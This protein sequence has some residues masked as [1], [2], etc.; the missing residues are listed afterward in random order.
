MFR[1]HREPPLKR[2]SL[3]PYL[4]PSVF[5]LVLQKSTP[6]QTVDSSL[7]INDIKNQLS[8]LC[9]NYLL[10]ND[11]QNKLC[12][13]NPHFVFAG[14]AT[15]RRDVCATWDHITAAF[16]RGASRAWRGGSF[17]GLDRGVVFVAGWEV[18]FSVCLRGGGVQGYLAHN[19][20][21]IPLGPP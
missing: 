10:Q 17:G 4:T 12:E 9:G 8:N 20:K 6:S 3:N 7:T 18:T 19:K 2:G 13:L 1:F 5:K 14:G 11:C 21:P 15:T 16:A